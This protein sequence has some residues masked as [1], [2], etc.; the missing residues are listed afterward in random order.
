MIVV[1]ADIHK[2]NHTLVAVD[3]QTG[4]A[5]GQLAIAA[6]DA[7]A[8]DALRFAIELDTDRVWAIEDCRHVSARLE[9]ALLAAGERVIRVPA[10]MT[11]QTR[12]LSRQAGK[13][14]PIDARA[15]ALAVVRDGVQSFPVAFC[16]EHALEIRVLCDYRDQIICE[17]TRMI[18]RL[19]WHLVTI[20]PELE[21]QIG[22][23][24]LKGPQICARLTRQ[25]ARLTPSPQLRVARALL[26]RITETVR[27]ERELVA[28]LTTL[29]QACAPHLLDQP[30]CGTVTAAIIVGHTAGA[31]RFATDGHFARHAGT[32][33]IPASSGKTQRHRLHRGGDRQ[34]N[35]AIH[36]IALSRVRTDPETRV[37]LDRKHAEGKTKRE[38]IRC[39]K[40]H[41]ARRI[42]RVLYSATPAE[43]PTTQTPGDPRR[44][45]QNGSHSPDPTP[46]PANP[47]RA[48]HSR[49]PIR[50]ARSPAARQDSCH[51]S[52]EI[53]QIAI[54]T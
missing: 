50:P 25:L 52:V 45:P 15:V 22:Q 32:A 47:V 42:W 30:G 6:S 7:G 21:A 3:G 33:P 48:Q 19:R 18:N 5:R 2:R 20:A 17:R 35:R 9:R 10:A 12:K 1:G 29:R 4:A 40:R 23:A 51:A 36:I 38:A 14:D 34:L 26:R 39:L 54:L 16:D 53:P 46:I 8:L 13:S 11:S 31:Q 24:A 28:E 44:D 43:N 41:V 27:E 49:P 37:Y